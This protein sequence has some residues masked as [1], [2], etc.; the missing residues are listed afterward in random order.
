MKT[1][2]P[3]KKE[4]TVPTVHLNG[5]GAANLK[6]DLEQA[7]RAV[8]AAHNAVAAMEVHGRD[9][10]VQADPNAFQHARDEHIDRLQRLEG[11]MD[12][13]LALFQAVEAQERR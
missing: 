7:Y 12:E 5:S 2:V 6:R 1:T 8:N 11:V 3:T 4:L 9:Y 10:Y 13:L